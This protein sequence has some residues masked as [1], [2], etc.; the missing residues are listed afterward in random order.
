MD[1][2]KMV[3]SIQVK[4]LLA[5]F[6]QESKEHR[7]NFINYFK[8]NLPKIEVKRVFLWQWVTFY[9]RGNIYLTCKK[10]NSSLHKKNTNSK[11]LHLKCE[12]GWRLNI[13][14]FN[15]CILSSAVY[16]L[17]TTAHKTMYVIM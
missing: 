3:Y 8:L 15:T 14:T 10:V 7:Q 17:H 6:Y 9:F 4:L 16:F 11:C 12:H 1:S 5:L 13:F 2:F